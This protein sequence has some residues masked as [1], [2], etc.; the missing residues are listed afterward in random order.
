M[1]SL[2]RTF[3]K[4]GKKTR[5]F[6]LWSSIYSCILWYRQ[7][8]EWMWWHWCRTFWSPFVPLLRTIRFYYRSPDFEVRSETGYGNCIMGLVHPR[9]GLLESSDTKHWTCLHHN[10]G[11]WG[12]PCTDWFLTNRCSLICYCLKRSKFFN[13]AV[14]PFLRSL[15]FPTLWFFINN[16]KPVNQ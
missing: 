14:C 1:N 12:K 11:K 13:E 15:L 10:E 8:T 3:T 9:F 16:L 6:P 4:M 5:N 7:R 2:S